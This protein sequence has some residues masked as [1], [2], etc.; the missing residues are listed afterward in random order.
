MLLAFSSKDRDQQRVK[1]RSRPTLRGPAVPTAEPPLTSPLYERFSFHWNISCCASGRFFSRF[2]SNFLV[3][4]DDSALS[5]YSFELRFTTRCALHIGHCFHI[6][7][8]RA[9][10]PPRI[11]LLAGRSLCA[12]TSFFN[13]IRIFVRWN[14]RSNVSFRILFFLPSCATVRFRGA[15]AVSRSAGTTG[16][17][18]F[19]ACAFCCWNRFRFISSAVITR[20]QTPRSGATRASRLGLPIVG[21]SINQV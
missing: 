17:R 1:A 12:A 10:F 15:C 2:A 18:S 5:F 8:L 14:C 4:R 20:K 21:H 16:W 6:R 19:C 9:R 3:S 13:N 11:T 7:I